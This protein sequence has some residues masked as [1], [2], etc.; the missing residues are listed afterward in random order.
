MKAA[1]EAGA[2]RD[3]E[4]AQAWR[5]TAAARGELAVR[6]AEVKRPETT[7]NAAMK[8]LDV[9]MAVD[10]QRFMFVNVRSP[11]TSAEDSA[12]SPTGHTGSME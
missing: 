11:A 8:G 2:L 12:I 5:E 6:T 9:G 10:C 3:Q 1:T 4:A 7:V